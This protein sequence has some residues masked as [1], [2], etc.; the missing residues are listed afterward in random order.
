VKEKRWV[1]SEHRE[2]AV[3]LG[4][5]HEVLD[6]EG[7]QLDVVQHLVQLLVEALY[8]WL[9]P[10]YCTFC[11]DNTTRKN[12]VTR[13]CSFR[14]NHGML[15]FIT[16]LPIRPQSLLLTPLPVPAAVGGTRFTLPRLSL[17][18]FNWLFISFILPLKS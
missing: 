10:T 4:N 9:F 16:W 5:A 3:L 6:Q 11:K 2:L 15:L 1:P 18:F 13:M 14:G 12:W 7:E 8:S 17:S